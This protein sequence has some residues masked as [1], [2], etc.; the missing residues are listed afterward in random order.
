MDLFRRAAKL[1]YRQPRRSFSVCRDLQGARTFK[2]HNDY[3]SDGDSKRDRYRFL[4]QRIAIGIGIVFCAPVNAEGIGG[5]SATAAPTATSSG[6]VQNSAVQI[7]Q[8]SAITNTYGGN[9]QCQGPTL[10]VTPYLNRTKSWGLPY[11]YSYQDPVYDLSDLD[12]D[13]RL[14]NP[15]DVLFYKDTRTGQRDNHNWNLGLSIQATIPLDGSLQERCKAAVDTQLAIQQQKLANLRLDFEL[16][17]KKTCGNLMKE[18]IRFKPSSPYAKVCA[19]VLIH[20]PTPHTH[21]IPST[22]S[23]THVGH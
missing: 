18:G 1:V 11:E 8:G 5:I 3:A 19:D 2:R 6:S 13:G 7:L 22:T 12:D 4:L 21:L 14:D 9:I 16:A 15:G 10:T 17:R 20:T 23:A